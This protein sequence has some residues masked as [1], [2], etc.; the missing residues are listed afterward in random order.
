MS[1]LASNLVGDRVSLL[2]TVAYTRFPGLW[3]SGDSLVSAFPP[4]FES[5]GIGYVL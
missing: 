5:V 2:F 4:Y 1:V 3:E